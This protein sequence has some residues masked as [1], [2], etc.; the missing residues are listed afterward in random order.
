[1]DLTSPCPLSA[2]LPPTQVC[3]VGY[4]SC[5][6]F[7]SFSRMKAAWPLSWGS[8]RDLGSR[9]SCSAMNSLSSLRPG[10]SLPICALT[11][12]MGR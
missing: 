4:V 11:P 3:V 2:P 12:R 9:R 7:I 8:R 5:L 6:E 10:L 1:M